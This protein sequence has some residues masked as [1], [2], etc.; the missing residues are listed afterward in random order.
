MTP[1]YARWP[2]S[3]H[4][5]PPAAGTAKTTR[6]EITRGMLG[7]SFDVT[8]QGGVRITVS[9]RRPYIAFGDYACTATK[10]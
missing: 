6:I 4:G 10:H 1:P 7:E 9:C 8:L 2:H 3:A 5:T